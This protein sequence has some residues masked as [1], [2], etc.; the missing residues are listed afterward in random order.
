MKEAYKTKQL[1]EYRHAVRKFF[2]DVFLRDAYLTGEPDIEIL[3][4]IATA[5]EL[6]RVRVSAIIDAIEE[7]GSIEIACYLVEKLRDFQ[8]CDEEWQDEADMYGR[9]F[10]Q[11][12]DD[13]R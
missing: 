11:L 1:I 7:V 10:N 13:A 12:E 6:A 9:I 3:L 5:E 2:L 8:E 4:E